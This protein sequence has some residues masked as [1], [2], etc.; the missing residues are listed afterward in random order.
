MIPLVL[1]LRKPPPDAAGPAGPLM[2]EHAPSEEALYLIL[3]LV[4]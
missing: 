1:L 3:R 2:A 4:P